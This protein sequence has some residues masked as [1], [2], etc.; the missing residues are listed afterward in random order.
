M[1][2]VLAGSLNVR[3]VMVYDAH[4]ITA[5]SLLAIFNQNSAS[6]GT[7]TF[8]RKDIQFLFHWDFGTLA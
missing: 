2:K 3:N 8:S 7:F 5:P 4:I 1:K 6:F